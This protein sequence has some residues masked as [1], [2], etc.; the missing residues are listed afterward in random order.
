M[1]FSQTALDHVCTCI[2]VCAETR[3]KSSLFRE[4][5]PGKYA[6]GNFRF[7]KHGDVFKCLTCLRT[8]DKKKTMIRHVR[9]HSNS[10]YTIMIFVVEDSK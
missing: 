2:S 9:R 3:P 5:E 8:A 7:E 6:V 1:N 10:K 4:I